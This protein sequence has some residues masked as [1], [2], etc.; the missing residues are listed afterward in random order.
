MEAADC[1]TCLRENSFW[2]SS[3]FDWEIPPLAP[4]SSCVQ[5]RPGQAFLNSE[6]RCTRF[7]AKSC[8]S[9][10][11]TDSVCPCLG[12]PRDVET[13]ETACLGAGDSAI[14]AGCKPRV[15]QRLA[16]VA[17]SCASS[18]ALCHERP[19]WT[20]LNILETTIALSSLEA[21]A[22]TDDCGSLE[23]LDA[24]LVGQT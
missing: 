14:G 22:S 18:R 13:K 6:S 7:T 10:C 17:L 4:W 19:P 8:H 16:E 9:A 1:G 15:C 23:V 3:F 12:G 5:P 20:A 2:R 21:L 11:Q 24:T